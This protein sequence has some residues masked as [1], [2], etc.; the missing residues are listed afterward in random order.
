MDQPSS[1]STRSENSKFTLEICID[2]WDSAKAAIDGGA[3]RLEVCSALGLGGLTPTRGLLIKIRDY[4]SQKPKTVH[5]AA[6]IRSRPGD[7]VYSSDEIDLMKME[8]ETLHDVCDSFVFGCLKVTANGEVTLEENHCRILV[9][10]CGSKPATFH[11]AIDVCSNPEVTCVDI[12]SLGFKR[13]LTSGGAATA[14]KGIEMI[15][16][17]QASYGDKITIMVGS[18]VNASNV[19]QIYEA[20]K[21]LDYHSS[22]SSEHVSSIDSICGQIFPS[23]VSKW[24]ITDIEKVIAMKKIIQEIEKQN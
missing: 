8:I 19:P 11:R 16:S 2:N 24:Q 10:A 9:T 5:V 14:L 15:K 3:N 1:E 17:L 18:G 7:F 4:L 13:I 21:V 6:M 12:I 23:G 20:T 22:C